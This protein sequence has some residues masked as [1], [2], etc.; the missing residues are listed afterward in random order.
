MFDI[1]PFVTG[2]S[3]NCPHIP[4]S[5]TR[6][7][8]PTSPTRPTC[9]TSLPVRLALPLALPQKK[10]LFTLTLYLRYTNN[11]GRANEKRKISEV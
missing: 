8:R 1:F 2:L 7:T 5:P 6:L 10:F 11:T 4:T 3:H 9:L